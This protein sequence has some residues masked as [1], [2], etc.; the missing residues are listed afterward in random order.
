MDLQVKKEF[1]ELAQ[2]FET[3]EFDLKT[4]SNI[5]VLVRR[6]RKEISNIAAKLLLEIPLNVLQNDVELN[7]KENWI[8]DNRGYFEGNITWV[9]DNFKN[10]WKKRFSSGNFGIEDIIE[11]CKIVSSDFEEHRS[12][13]E[14]LLRNVEVTLR[15]D[16]TVLSYSNFYNSGRVFASQIFKAIEI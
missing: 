12:S 8:D 16:V 3:G 9:D 10:E 7:D 13:C 1:N 15:D 4:V 5:I 2:K 14:F 6:Y 11:L